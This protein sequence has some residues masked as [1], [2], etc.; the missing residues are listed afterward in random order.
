MA[1]RKSRRRRQKE[2]RKEV[3]TILDIKISKMLILICKNIVFKKN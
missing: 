3:N 2:R 1:R